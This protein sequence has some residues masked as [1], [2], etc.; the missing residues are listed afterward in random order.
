VEEQ[1][2]RGAIDVPDKIRQMVER[3]VARFRPQQIILFGSHA[4]GE[5]GPDS[6]V[7]LLVVMPVTGSR[8][9]QAAAIAV[10]VSGLGLPKDVIVV[11][12]EEVERD[13][14]V[15][16]T[17]IYPALREGTVLYDRAA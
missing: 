14:N 8:R 15:P 12:P 1:T 10:E 16:G 17:M 5:A 2:R 13:R 7:D 9:K 3:I 11:T 6:D 4:R